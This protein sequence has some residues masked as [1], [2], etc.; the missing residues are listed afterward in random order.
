MNAV[1]IHNIDKNLLETNLYIQLG[2]Y[3]VSADLIDFTEDGIVFDINYPLELDDYEINFELFTVPYDC[4]MQIIGRSFNM[5]TQSTRYTAKLVNLSE[6]D[7]NLIRLSL[8]IP[9][10]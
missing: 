3:S 9:T 4:S 10:E 2:D 1:R 7:N 5:R 8:G 6:E